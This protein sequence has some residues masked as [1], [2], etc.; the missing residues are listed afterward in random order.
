MKLDYHMHF[1]KGSYDLDWAEGFFE[2][3][4]KRGLDEIGI[5]EH[6]HTFPEFE[7][8]YYHDLI[9]DDGFIGSFQKTWLKSNKFKY[10]LD[11][12]FR[13][14]EQLRKRHPNVRTGIEVCNFQQQ[15]KVHDILKDYPFDYIIGSVHFLR[16]WAYDSSEI[17]AEWDRHPLEDIYEWYAE[18]VEKLADSGE[19]DILGHPF[20]IRL[21]KY[22]PDFDVTPY[23]ERVARAMAKAKMVVDINTGTYYRYPIQEISP[24]P[25]FLCMARKYDLPIIT[26]SDAHQPEDCGAYNDEAVQYARDCGYTQLVH[27][28]QR[29]RT[30]VK[31]G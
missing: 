4:K 2:A 7:A 17:K 22:I 25:D 20:N 19:Y 3:A 30:L 23:L 18:E 10:T 16:G 6:S 8:L 9:L 28:E 13:F 15:D 1:E 29:R 14:M 12:Y 11:D 5:S 21:F 31:L 24:Y 27:F 26:S